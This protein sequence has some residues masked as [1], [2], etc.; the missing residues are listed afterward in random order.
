M[1]GKMNFYYD[2]KGDILDMSI[3]RPRKAI[4]RE[5]SDDILIRVIPETKE[6]VGLT[7]L[8]FGKRFGKKAK[9]HVIPLF[10]E[11]SA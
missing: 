11:L 1:E 4:S 9:S 10:A 5:V 7:I 6:V 3:G 8:N 2:E